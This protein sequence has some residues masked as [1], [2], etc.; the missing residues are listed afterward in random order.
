MQKYAASVKGKEDFT[1]TSLSTYAFT[2]GLEYAKS[3]K[4]GLLMSRCASV[5]ISQRSKKKNSTG[6]A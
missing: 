3:F 5:E 2:I 6:V 4:K 1:S